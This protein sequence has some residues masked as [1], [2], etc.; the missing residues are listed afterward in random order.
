[1][2]RNGRH[3]VDVTESD[4]DGRF[5]VLCERSSGDEFRVDARRRDGPAW[6]ESVVGADFRAGSLLAGAAGPSWYSEPASSIDG[7]WQTVVRRRADVIF[8]A[9]FEGGFA[10]AMGNP[11]R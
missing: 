2:R 10:V 9:E 3:P 5:W 8:D 11:G 4:R 7:V 6:S 1:M